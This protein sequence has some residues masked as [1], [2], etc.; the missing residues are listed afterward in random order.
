MSRRHE[1]PT[2]PEP[3]TTDDREDQLPRE[4]SAIGVD[5]NHRAEDL[6]AVAGSEFVDDRIRVG[7]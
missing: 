4:A 6:D 5:V 7:E 2:V 3:P 1:T